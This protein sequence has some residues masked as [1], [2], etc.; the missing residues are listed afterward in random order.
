MVKDARRLVRVLLVRRAQVSAGIWKVF[1]PAFW[2][3]DLLSNC[4]ADLFG[5]D[6]GGD[7]LCKNM[8]LPSMSV[9]IRFLSL[10]IA[11]GI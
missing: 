7:C 3:I 8:V 10:I 1:K 9:R 4:S 11:A 6:I 5:S 2:L